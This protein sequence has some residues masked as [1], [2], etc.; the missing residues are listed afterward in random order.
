[1]TFEY[2]FVDKA[3]L[4]LVKDFGGSYHF[5]FIMFQIRASGFSNAQP[6]RKIYLIAQGA[7][8]K[9]IADLLKWLEVNQ[10]V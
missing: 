7:T 1:V 3:T 4:K 9:P 2:N 8:A 5:T 6:L 10:T